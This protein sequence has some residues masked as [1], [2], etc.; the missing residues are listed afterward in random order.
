MTRKILTLAETVNASTASFPIATGTRALIDLD[1]MDRETLS[2]V[3]AVHT[4]SGW[5]IAYDYRDQSSTLVCL[6]GKDWRGNDRYLTY[7]HRECP[8]QEGDPRRETH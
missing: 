8:H 6:T 2:D 5:A 4:I 1:A 3:M 7:G